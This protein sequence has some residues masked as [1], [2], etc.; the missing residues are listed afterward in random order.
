MKYARE[1]SVLFSFMEDQSGEAEGQE[2][3]IQ[4]SLFHHFI[5]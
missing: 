2:Q 3:Q 5:I 1:R 4:P